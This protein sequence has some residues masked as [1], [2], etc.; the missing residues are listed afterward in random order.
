MADG[1]FHRSN[2]PTNNYQSGVRA[3]AAQ[4]QIRALAAFD[5]WLKENAGCTVS[6]DDD[7]RQRQHRRFAGLLNGE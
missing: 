5:R 3:G 4:M 2:L 6:D 1:N 7:E